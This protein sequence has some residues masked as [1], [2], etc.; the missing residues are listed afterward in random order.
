[1]GAKSDC[2]SRP[3]TFCALCGSRPCSSLVRNFGVWSP[4][5]PPTTD[6]QIS[7]SCKPYSA[8]WNSF[9]QNCSSSSRRPW[10]DLAPQSCYCVFEISEGSEHWFWTTS[11]TWTDCSTAATAPDYKN[12]STFFQPFS[13]IIVVLAWRYFAAVISRCSFRCLFGHL[14][15]RS[16]KQ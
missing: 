16:T 5:K 7:S 1:M 13:K 14:R 8:K 10:S 15:S 2:C 3:P 6:W 9:P 12:Q 4:T 11:N